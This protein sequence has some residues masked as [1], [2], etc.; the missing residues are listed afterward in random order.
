MDEYWIR[1]VWRWSKQKNIVL[2]DYL[3]N[4]TA[5]AAGFEHCA[6][7]FE[8]KN[9]TKKCEKRSQNERS[10]GLLS[11]KLVFE[12]CEVNILGSMNTDIGI[13]CV[14]VCVL[15]SFFVYREVRPKIQCIRSKTH[16]AMQRAMSMPCEI[17]WKHMA[18]CTLQTHNYYSIIILL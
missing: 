13:V 9:A 18:N 1:W 11:I 10:V 2:K 3:K 14:C 15:G 12:W 17:Q 8:D 6:K 16:A 7:H 4:T 5:V